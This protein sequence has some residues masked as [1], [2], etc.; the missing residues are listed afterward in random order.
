MTRI[1]Y[2]SDFTL[3][4]TLTNHEGGT[5]S[6]PS[7]HAWSVHIRD[8]AGTC[9]RC[10]FDGSSYEDCAVDGDTIVCYVNNPGYVPGLLHVTYVD[11]IPDSNYAD[12]YNN[13]V[14]PA[15]ADVMLWDGATDDGATVDIDLLLQVI[16]PRVTAANVTSV[17]DLVLTFNN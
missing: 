14:A 12:G 15:V 3:L 9:W 13:Q 7:G 4:V 17:G 1:N 6:P 5:M 10:G 11:A 2:Q 8:D 16:A